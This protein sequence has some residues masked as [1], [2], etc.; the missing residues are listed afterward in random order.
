MALDG[1]VQLTEKDEFAYQE[2]IAFL[3]LNSHPEPKKVLII[4]GGDGGVIREVLKHPLV[5]EIVLCEIDEAV[6]RVSRKYLRFMSKHFDDPKVKILIQDGYK[7]IRDNKSAF[8][9]IITDSSDPKGPAV[10]LFQRE[11]Y[12]SLHECLRPGG[13]IYLSN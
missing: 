6:I 4:G 5:E 12:L 3:P 8:D 2:M 7:Y 1:A 11:Y 9:V 10:S 13:S